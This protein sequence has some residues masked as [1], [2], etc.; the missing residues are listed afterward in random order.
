M[1]DIKKALLQWFTHFF[2]KK[3]SDMCANKFAG[4][5]IKNENISSKELAD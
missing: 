4:S 3:T 2:G 5:V 1:M